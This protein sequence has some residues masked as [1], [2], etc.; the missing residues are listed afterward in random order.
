MADEQKVETPAA[1]AIDMAALEAAMQRSVTAGIQSMAEKAAQEQQQRELQAQLQAQQ[2]EREADP[3][4]KTVQ[5]IVQPALNQLN[6][7]ADNAFDYAQFYH[8]HPEATKYRSDV[9]GKFN[10]FLSKGLPIQRR[11]VWKWVQGEKMDEIVK[12]RMTQREA[13]ERRAHEAATVNGS[14][15]GVNFITHADPDAMDDAQLGELMN[16][17]TF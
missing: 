14:R 8:E 12:D 17:R 10:E 2:R 4:H 11:D 9:E 13:D 5:P 7:K 6:L 16:G 1:P 3:V 15:G